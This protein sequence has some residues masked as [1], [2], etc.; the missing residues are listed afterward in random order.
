M[1]LP[2]V[3]CAASPISLAHLRL[4]VQQPPLHERL[5]LREERLVVE[6]RRYLVDVL[7]GRIE[8][9]RELVERQVAAFNAEGLESEVGE[10]VVGNHVG[11]EAWTKVSSRLGEEAGWLTSDVVRVS[12]GHLSV[13]LEAVKDVDLLVHVVADERQGEVMKGAGL[14]SS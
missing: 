8:E 11:D 5:R 3:V 1:A 2:Q 4:R 12:D 7:D 10:R 6:V 14:G 13:T 9:S